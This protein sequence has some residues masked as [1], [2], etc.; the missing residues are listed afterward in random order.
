MSIPGGKALG[1]LGSHT[2]GAPIGSPEDYWYVHFAS[3]HVECLGC[4]VDHLEK[5]MRSFAWIIFFEIFNK[6]ANKRP[7]LSPDQ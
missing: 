3:G 1:V 4:R 5:F 7:L 2:F 6:S